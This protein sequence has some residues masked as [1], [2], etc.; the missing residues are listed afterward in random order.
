MAWPNG[1]L[2]TLDFGAFP[3]V[4]EMAEIPLQEWQE[5]V[6]VLFE[7]G[8]LELQF[9]SPLA[10]DA[11]ARVELTRPGARDEILAPTMPRSWSFR[12]QAEA[13]I[14]DIHARREPLASGRDSIGDLRLAEAI[15]A[16]HLGRP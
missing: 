6:E 5:G 4:L 7:K 14:A 3:A 12:R 16:R 15:W 11:P 1:R 8:W 13:F 2:V 10:R 9:P